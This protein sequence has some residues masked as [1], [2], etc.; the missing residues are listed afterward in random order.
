MRLVSLLYCVYFTT[1]RNK[2]KEFKNVFNTPHEFLQLCADLCQKCYST[3]LRKF[4]GTFLYPPLYTVGTSHS[5]T[6][7]PSDPMGRFVIDLTL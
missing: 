5:M 4:F 2:Q 6:L 7:L 1:T 3:Q